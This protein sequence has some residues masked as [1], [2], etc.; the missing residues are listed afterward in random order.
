VA[1][2]GVAPDWLAALEAGAP[3]AVAA[4]RQ[5]ADGRPIAVRREVRRRAGAGTA[6]AILSQHEAVSHAFAAR[7]E[8]LP[9]EAFAMPGGEADWSVAEALG[10]AFASRDGLATAAS[11]AAAGR[12]PEDAP[13]VVPGVPG[14]AGA[15]RDSLARRLAV[16]RRILARAARSITGH[17][18]AACPLEHPL[19]GTLRCGEWYLFAAV[20]D[21]MHLGQLA[22]LAAS[23]ELAARLKLAAG[24]ERRA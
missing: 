14:D 17:E 11:L 22:E 24:P 18:L 16:S 7:I 20:H 12:F 3:D 1:E 10:H 5:L 4:F 13:R 19:V 6:M 8:T 2:E 21:L 23:L 9:A 15:T